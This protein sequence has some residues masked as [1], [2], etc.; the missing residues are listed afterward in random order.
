MLGDLIDLAQ[1]NSVGWPAPHALPVAGTVDAGRPA[2]R[3]HYLR[4]TGEAHPGLERRIDSLVRRAGLSV[5]NRASRNEDSEVHLGLM[6]SA[7]SEDQIAEV[8]TTVAQLARVDQCL[9]LGV[10]E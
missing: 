1:D 4:A 8:R 7:G 2:P 10:M 3:R 9:C 6:I 5:Q